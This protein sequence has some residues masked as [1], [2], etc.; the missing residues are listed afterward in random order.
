M[1][2]KKGQAAGAAVLLAVIMG[3]VILFILLMPP[4]ERAQLLGEP[5][6]SRPSARP[7]SA[8]SPPSQIISQVLLQETPGQLSYIKEREK[9]ISIPSAHIFTEVKSTILEET[10]ELLVKKAVFS[11]QPF[12]IY[13][14]IADLDK[15]KEVLLDFTIEAYQGRLIIL[16]NNQEIFNR[17][18]NKINPL[19]LPRRL[20]TKS[21]TL[22]FQVSSPGLAFWRTNEYLLKNIKIVADITDLSAQESRHLFYIKPE[23]SQNIEETSLRFSLSCLPEKMGKLI[24]KLNDHLVFSGVPENCEDIFYYNLPPQAIQPGDNWVSFKTE[25]GDYDLSHIA[26]K[27]KLTAPSYPVYYFEINQDYFTATAEKEAVCGEIDNLCPDD[28]DEDLDPDCCFQEYSTP[29][30]CAARTRNSDDR[31]VGSV[32]QTDCQ[33]C[34]SGYQDQSSTPPESCQKLCGD[35]TDDYCP[36]DCNPHYDKDCCFQ[37]SGQQFWC[38]H[39]PL[40]GIDFTCVDSVSQD[41]CTICPSPGSYEGEE[42]SPDCLTPTEISEEQK[43]KDDYDVILTL[44]FSDDDKKEAEIYINGHK[45]SFDTYKVEFTRNL[46][47]DVEPWTNSLKIIPKTSFDVR[48]LKVEL[49]GS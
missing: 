23:E 12:E 45:I 43:L 27:T 17:E 29:F 18:T 13:F 25:E 32:A 42:S 36:S 7:P 30:W 47:T 4:T 2:N 49:K 6:P 33:R 19:R 16:L 34:S 9:E 41:E 37:Q 22:L 21:N 14:D 20:L 3:L 38:P 24:V 44:E 10:D 8:P 5:S 48:T 1:I 15:T 35:D 46:D 40:N 26:V 28:C 11:S 39:L 31:C